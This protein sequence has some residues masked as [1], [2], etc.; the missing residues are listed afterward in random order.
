MYASQKYQFNKQEEESYKQAR[1]N[2]LIEM[3]YNTQQL[4]SA[5]KIWARE[6]E[7]ERERGP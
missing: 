2:E 6:R 4:I 7:R 1:E 5:S 3:K